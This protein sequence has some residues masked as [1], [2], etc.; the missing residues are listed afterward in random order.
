[1]KKLNIAKNSVNDFST[2]KLIAS[3]ALI[4]SNCFG[5]DYMESF[6]PFLATL[7][8]KKRYEEIILDIIINDFCNEFGFKIPRLPMINLLNLASEKK[9]IS[10]SS[11]NHYYPSY[12][13]IQKLNFE[14]TSN[15]FIKKID[16]VIN[17]LVEYAKRSDLDLTKE[18]AESYLLSFL[19]NHSVTTFIENLSEINKQNISM[20]SVNYVVSSFI[21][22]SFANNHSISSLLK[23]IAFGHMVASAVTLVKNSDSVDD[24]SNLCIYLDTKFVLRLI[25]IEGTE[26]EESYIDLTNE[27]KQKGATL[28]IFQHT[29]EEI[30]SI[31]DDCEKWIENPKYDPKCASPALREFILRRYSIHDVREYIVTLEEKFRE[32]EI[33]IDNNDYYSE[34]YHKL[35]QNNENFEKM[36]IDSYK[37]TNSTF[38]ELEKFSTIKKDV[39][40]VMSIFKLRNSTKSQNI[41]NCNYIFITVNQSLAYV[42]K[43]YA[44][45]VYGQK[46]YMPPTVTD[47]FFGTKV[48]LHSTPQ[49]AF[50]YSR[51]KLVAD[52]YAA[53]SPNEKLLSKFYDEIYDLR[54]NKKTITEKQYFLLRS[55]GTKK[56][57]LQKKTL[58]DPNLFTDTTPEEICK[59]IEAEIR[60][61]IENE[62]AAANFKISIEEEKRKDVEK[63]NNK[64]QE[65][66]KISLLN[67]I[68]E[69]KKIRENED[70]CRK[71]AT[72][73]YKLLLILMP[74]VSAIFSLFFIILKIKPNLIVFSNFFE[75]LSGAISF[76]F[77]FIEIICKLKKE[78]LIYYF[79]KNTL[80]KE[81]YKN[82]KIQLKTIINNIKF[83]QD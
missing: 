17:S 37:R 60:Q 42:S 62:L 45:I 65:I 49:K 56:N 47:V 30:V 51:K 21:E 77:I 32:L 74:S 69:Y 1:M 48:W 29:Y 4:K 25:G 64:I 57:Y 50:E 26:R 67:T 33:S 27:V 79:F 20:D 2:N 22:E 73:K 66:L 59:I 78:T 55:Y 15:S 34:Q 9:I 61:P 36:L 53:I 80:L 12:E 43:L 46:N 75:L 82:K 18:I 41:I 6:I 28:H 44:Q 3:F 31:L 58:N 68:K 40:S 23:D 38:N 81:E 5:N 71:K 83:P 11:S 39:K 63:V 19:D 52:C 8:K 35:E 10:K 54:Y 7:I 72:D 70:K 14:S 24:L 76:V 16:T 13:S